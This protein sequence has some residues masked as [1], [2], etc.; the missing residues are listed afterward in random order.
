M[1]YR[2]DREALR[3]EV[4]TLQQELAAAKADQERFQQL[5]QRLEATKREMQALEAELGRARPRSSRGASRIVVPIALLVVAAAGG[6]VLLLARRPAPIAAPVITP[7]PIP[8]PI[9][10]P[11]SPPRDPGPAQT[12]AV[13]EAK[14][15]RQ[16]QLAWSATVTKSTEPTVHQGSP[17]RISANAVPDSNGMHVIDVKV[18]CGARTIYDESSPLNGMSM[19]DSDANQRPGPRIGTWVYDLVSPTRATARPR[20]IKRSSTRR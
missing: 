5:E 12:V 9:P 7:T 19:L 17:C 14:P 6:A 20:R 3:G 15:A 18:T 2:D 11:N 4:D 10:E 16:V 8:A 1:N 13:A